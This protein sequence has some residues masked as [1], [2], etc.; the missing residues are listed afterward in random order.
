VRYHV[1]PS[2]ESC[3]GACTPGSAPDPKLDKG[4]TPRD[5]FLARILARKK[6]PEEFKVNEY[7]RTL[8][9]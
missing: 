2:V 4:D 5:P 1:A 7:G 8:L 6:A 3:G 9:G